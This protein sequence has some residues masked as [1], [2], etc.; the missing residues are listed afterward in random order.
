[1]ELCLHQCPSNACSTISCWFSPKASDANIAKMVKCLAVLAPTIAIITLPTLPFADLSAW[2]PHR[3]SG[4]GLLLLWL[5]PRD[6]TTLPGSE[7]L[8]QAQVLH[9]AIP[10]GA[11]QQCSSS[12][13]RW[14]STYAS[15]TWAQNCNMPIWN[16]ETVYKWSQPFSPKKGLPFNN[17]SIV[18]PPHSLFLWKM[19]RSPPCLWQ[20]PF[21][22]SSSG[23]AV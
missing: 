16:L 1:M 13:P 18:S 3:A 8:C 19:K 20:G 10:W 22:V 21:S 4:T 2:L 23:C 11:D 14:T 6:S 15:S 12:S 17:S 5:C 7:V 9:Q